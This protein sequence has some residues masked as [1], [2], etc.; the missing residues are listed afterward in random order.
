MNFFSDLSSKIIKTAITY[1]CYFHTK[2]G[3]LSF[4][5][6]TYSCVIYTAY[7]FQHMKICVSSVNTRPYPLSHYLLLDLLFHNLLYTVSCC[8][9]FR[10]LSLSSNTLQTLHPI[11]QQYSSRNFISQPFKV[12][13]YRPRCSEIAS[14]APS[15][16]QGIFSRPFSVTRR[17]GKN[18][19]STVP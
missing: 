8:S 1:A 7:K 14:S 18:A 9:T 17:E 10:L 3:F 2:S 13:Q 11:S 5:T 15:S 16:T 19:H 4:L 6:D 12:F